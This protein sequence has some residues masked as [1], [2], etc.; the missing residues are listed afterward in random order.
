MQQFNMEIS[1]NS[2]IVKAGI[3][4][5]TLDTLKYQN[6]SPRWIEVMDRSWKQEQRYEKCLLLLNRGIKMRE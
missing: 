3:V 4:A 5:L 6:A 2:E 1:W